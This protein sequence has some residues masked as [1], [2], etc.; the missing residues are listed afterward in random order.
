[1]I[2]HLLIRDSNLEI[3]KYMG[4]EDFGVQKYGNVVFTY[5]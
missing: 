2:I 5:E 1:M 4:Y 3:M